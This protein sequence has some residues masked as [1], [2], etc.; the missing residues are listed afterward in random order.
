MGGVL[1]TLCWRDSFKYT[2]LNTD[3][4]NEYNESNFSMNALS[5]ESLFIV[6]GIKTDLFN[7]QNS[8]FIPEMFV[9]LGEF[10]MKIEEL[11]LIKGNVYNL[12]GSSN[13]GKCGKSVFC[14]VL[15]GI[16]KPDNCEFFPNFEIAYKP[17]YICRCK[18]TGTVYNFI[19]N[20]LKEFQYNS[21][22]K[23]EYETNYFHDKNVIIEDLNGLD[24]S[25]KRF[26]AFKELF[27]IPFD[28]VHIYNK[29]IQELS[30]YEWVILSIISTIVNF[31]PNV[32]IIDEYVWLTKQER[33]KIAKILKEFAK[34]FNK[35]IIIVE[36]D[37]TVSLDN[38][39]HF[40]KIVKKD[41]VQIV[42]QK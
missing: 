12:I 11:E 19:K 16:L 21:I 42:T 37:R 29:S 27:L 41:Y 2:P 35:I 24:S 9:T 32:Y 17:Q 22:F 39:E 23:N 28:I 25:K 3:E 6:N 34:K 33:D 5:N 7:N 30:E 18:Y 20:Y 15:S 8:L 40:I 1:D 36:T 14:K 31:S 4:Y 10:L 26:D 38:Y 13:L